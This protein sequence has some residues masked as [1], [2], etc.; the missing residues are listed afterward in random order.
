MKVVLQL[1]LAF[2]LISTTNVSCQSETKEKKGINLGLQ[3][4]SF[5]TMENQSP[6]AIL[7]YIKQTGIKQVELMGNHAEPFAGAPATPVSNPKPQSH[8]YNPYR[9]DSL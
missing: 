7:E 4:Y 6:R 9:D 2:T 1:I 3:T 5:R 8:L